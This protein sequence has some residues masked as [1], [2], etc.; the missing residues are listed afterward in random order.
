MIIIRWIC[1]KCNKKWLYPIEK[2]I[3]CKGNTKK[4]KGTKIKVIGFTKVLIPSPMHPIIPYNVL[5]LQDEYGNRI[6]KKTM[7]DYTIGDYY[8][9]E[10]AKTE[11]AVAIVK[12]KYDVYEAIKEAIELINIIDFDKDDKILIKPSSVMASYQYQAVTT[13]PDVISAILRI[14]FEIGIKKENIIIA[15]QALIGNDVI[16]AASKSGILEV[17]K[18]NGIDFVDISKGV[19]E[20]I[21]INGFKFNIFKEAL[22]RRLINVPVMKTNSQIVLSG[23][24]EN[25][26]RLVDEQTQKEMFWN[27]IEKTLPKLAKKFTNVLNIADATAGMQGQGPLTL[28]EPAFLNLILASRSAANLDAVFC[29]D[30]MMEIPPYISFET[31]FDA[32]KIE[33]VGNQLEAVKYQIK[34]PS[35]DETPHQDIKV[36]DGKACP[37]CFNKMFKITSRLVGLRG[38]QINLAIGPLLSKSMLAGKDRIVLFGDC[39]IKRN[40]ELGIKPMATISE[41]V[42]E[43]EQLVLFKKL[44]ISKGE[45]PITPVDK[46]KSKMKKL[47]YKIVR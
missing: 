13:N 33:V 30:T 19:F 46:V 25:L 8:V 47:L 39:A 22:D 15:E 6:P 21:E 3:Y 43:V 35:P 7:K 38:E 5:L 12:V 42:D 37:S 24:V 44:L 14:L 41:N 45:T 17:C 28:G 26:L 10:K 20:Q 4:Q 31:G 27:D 1:E 23:A 36:I 34:T 16:D 40:E 9:E 18:K 2:C 11:S 32:K 29:E